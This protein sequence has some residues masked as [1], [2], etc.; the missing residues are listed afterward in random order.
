MQRQCGCLIY[1][2]VDFKKYNIRDLEEFID[3]FDEPNEVNS[4]GSILQDK[5]TAIKIIIPKKYV[6]GDLLSQLELM[7]ILGMYLYDTPEGVSIDVSN[8]FFYDTKTLYSRNYFDAL[9]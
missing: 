2:T 8:S 7:G 5:H 4:D 1:D 9:T 3:D 6:A